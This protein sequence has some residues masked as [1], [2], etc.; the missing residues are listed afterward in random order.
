MN[1]SY[2]GQGTDRI[3][4]PVTCK[5]CHLYHFIC[6][7]DMRFRK[8][9]HNMGPLTLCSVQTTRHVNS[10]ENTFYG[11]GSSISNERLKIGFCREERN[12]ILTT[13]F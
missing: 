1:A 2:G 5:F 4:I 11:H 12:I 8:E 10:A 7:W 13:L 3:H 6:T 9:Y